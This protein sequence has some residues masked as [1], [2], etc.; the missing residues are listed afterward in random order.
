MAKKKYLDIEHK[1]RLLS[2]LMNRIPDVIYFKDNQGRFMMVNQAHAKGLGLKPEDL[3]GKTDFDLFPKERA[4]MMT[5][6]DLYVLKSGKPIV[7]KIERATRPDGV[8]NYV[9]TSKIPRFNKQG[10]VIGL[11]GITRDI[12]HRMQF[13]RIKDEKERIEKKLRMLKSLNRIRSEFVAVLSH[14][15]KTP[16]AIANESLRQVS[17]EPPRSIGP[18]QKKLLSM[19]KNNL[20][21]LSRLIDNLLDMSRIERQKLKLHYALVNL[22]D[23]I[24]SQ[25]E[26]FRKLARDKGVK[27]MY[28]LPKEQGNIFVDG[29][30]IS[31]VFTNL[32]NNAL[33]FTEQNGEI[34]VEVKILENKIRVGVIDTGVGIDRDDLKK[35][36]SRF[37]Q[38]SNFVESAG[39]GLGLGLSISKELI[40]LHGGEIWAES[41]PG[42]GSR[43]YFTM[44]KVYSIKM[45]TRNN[46]EKINY[47]LNRSTSVHLV[48]ISIIHFNEFKRALNLKSERLFADLKNI[49][50]EVL[51]EF[52]WPEKHRRPIILEDYRYGIISTVFSEVPEKETAKIC[53][54][55]KEKIRNYFAR[56]KAEN[57]F[58]NL[59]MMSY[60]LHEKMSTAMHL[61]AHIY[62]KKIY[63]GSEIRR[64][65]RINYRANIEILHS[66]KKKELLQ[67][68]DISS[69]GI[70]FISKTPLETETEVNIRIG[71][72]H[73]KPLY[74]RGKVAWRRNLTEGT[75]KSRAEKYK[76]GLEF[77]DL[78]NKKRQ[79]QK[80]IK[81]ISSS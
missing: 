37:T 78:K 42:V 60:P 32:I 74:L 22:N 1:Y 65:K 52:S 24:L 14:E 30:R 12:T 49:I 81:S 72:E 48:N 15:L 66:E 80:L 69:M 19:A 76:I 59:G 44:P 50:R 58:I 26:Y 2:D 16:L 56:F 57:V 39:K 28:S 51:A 17:E 10:K 29:E 7:D 62:V 9:S 68:I 79:I 35:L 41:T 13:E 61:L 75:K 31:Q 38:V 71:V 43:F 33:K 11:V 54:L 23:L 34:T 47:L 67:T 63:I 40:E 77:L 55:L 45:L 53:D 73:G 20:G 27:L 46:R 6:D 64:F 18:R 70:C 3:I 8:D 25:T 21:R 5:K 4:E 36:F